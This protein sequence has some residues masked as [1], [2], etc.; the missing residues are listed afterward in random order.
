M[1]EVFDMQDLAELLEAAAHDLEHEALDAALKS[2]R[3][4]SAA[5]RHQYRGEAR[6]Y[7]RSAWIVRKVATCGE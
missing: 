7:E 5:S 4:T 2:A 3:A 1:T 6:A